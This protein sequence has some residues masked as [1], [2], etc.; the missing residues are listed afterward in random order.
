MKYVLILLLLAGC[1]VVPSPRVVTIDGEQYLEF[2]GVA[3][4][5]IEHT[6]GCYDKSRRAIWFSPAWDEIGRRYEHEH[7]RGLAHGAWV[8]DG[9]KSCAIVI[10]AGKTPWIRGQEICRVGAGPFFA[11]G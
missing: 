7:V 6:G 4:P 11:V 8:W 3:C 10:Q 1:A 9:V 2:P 5:A